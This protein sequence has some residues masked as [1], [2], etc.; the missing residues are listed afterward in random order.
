MC[1]KFIQA[2]AV[3]IMAVWFISTNLVMA[4]PPRG[5]QAGR[6]GGP[7]RS[8]VPYFRYDKAI[9]DSIVFKETIAKFKQ[10]S[11]QD[12]TTGIDLPYNLFVPLTHRIIYNL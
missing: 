6:G 9:P 12:K 3:S 8:W 7:T 2:L 5:Q 10:L 4:Q 1:K 11:Y